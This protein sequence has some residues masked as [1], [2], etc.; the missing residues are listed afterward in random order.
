MAAESRSRC[1]S[2]TDPASRRL[3]LWG[4]AMGGSA[5]W[6]WVDGKLRRRAVSTGGAARPE[7]DAGA[8]RSGRPAA[9]AAYAV[10]IATVFWMW[11]DFTSADAVTV[12]DFPTPRSAAWAPMVSEGRDAGRVRRPDLDVRRDAGRG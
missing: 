8:G 1:S 3:C 4:A 7:D 10:E 2:A 11:P 9:R 5:T 12:P 6:A